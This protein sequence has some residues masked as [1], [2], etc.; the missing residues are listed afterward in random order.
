MNFV[1]W[2]WGQK[3]EPHKSLMF[4]SI[5]R[6]SGWGRDIVVSKRVVA[7]L[8]LFGPKIHTHRHNIWVAQEVLINFS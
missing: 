8:G 6:I 3:L 4:P 5:S 7:T 2:P 1:I